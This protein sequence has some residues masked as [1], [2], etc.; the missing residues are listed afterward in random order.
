MAF[1]VKQNGNRVEI[2]GG[3]QTIFFEVEEVSLPPLHDFSFAVWSLLPVA[4]RDGF[5]IEIDG[6][7]DPVVADNARRFSR[8]WE[9]WMPGVFHE[10][11]V[12]GSEPSDRSEGNRPDLMLFSGGVDSTHM[13]LRRGRREPRSTV[14]TLQS[15]ME[16]AEGFAAL[17][18]RTQPVLDDLN[19]DRMIVRTNAIPFRPGMSRGGPK[20]KP[21]KFHSYALLLA[22]PA[23]LLSDLFSEAYFAADFS[24]EQDV[25]AFPYGSNHITNRYLRGLSFRLQVLDDDVTK[26]TKIANI[27]AKWTALPTLSFCIRKE[28]RPLNCGTCD[29]CVRTKAIFAVMLG[30]MPDIFY[31][32]SFGP[33]LLRVLDLSNGKRRAFLVDLYQHA[34][35]RGAISAVPGLEE[36]FQECVGWTAKLYPQKDKGRGKNRLGGSRASHL[37]SLKKLVSPAPLRQGLKERS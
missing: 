3:S 19:Y 32:R 27:A 21:I 2:C 8:C 9:L 12:A 22:G 26:T 10:V 18:R 1:R 13:L 14:L 17:L 31:D 24:W 23:F 30:H 15:T 7:V 34:R 16:N 11:R 5:D 28:H 4:M 6:P 35:D 37:H 20:L 33:E 36:R 29:K 25:P